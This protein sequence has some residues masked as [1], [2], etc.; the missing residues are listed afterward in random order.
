MPPKRIVAADAA[1]ATCQL[2]ASK[3]ARQVPVAATTR[4]PLQRL[5][6]GWPLPKM[7][8]CSLLLAAAGCC[9]LLLA[10]DAA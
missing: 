6:G 10:A 5:V 2:P 8:E 3:P 1:M 9:W 4:R 7:A